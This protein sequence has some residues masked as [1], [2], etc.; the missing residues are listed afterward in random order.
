[1]HIRAG[2]TA[3]DRAGPRPLRLSGARRASL[4]PDGYLSARLAN[5]LVG[6]A[7]QR[8]DS[9]DHARRSATH[10]RRARH[11]SPWRAPFEVTNRRGHPASAVSSRVLPGTA[12]AV[13]AA[14]RGARAYL[15][16]AAASRRPGARQPRHA[17]S[18]PH[19][20]RRWPR[21]RAG[22]VCRLGSRSA[23]VPPPQLAPLD[24][25]ALA[26]S[27]RDARSAS[28]PERP[29]DDASLLEPSTTLCRV[30]FTLSARVRPHGLRLEGPR[31]APSGRSADILSDA[32]PIGSLQVPPSG[33][34]ILLM[35]D[36]QTPADTRRLRR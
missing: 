36:R 18:Q 12:S 5:R 25:A 31:A 23:R 28:C 6:N 29:H 10:D 22:D 21:A 1:M 33:Q 11:G 16:V 26:R 9:G 7:D 35:A 13:R 17:S 19:G 14:Q 4:R 32:T 2:G 3:D 34:P 8:G 24:L 15:A 20:R 27:K 30:P